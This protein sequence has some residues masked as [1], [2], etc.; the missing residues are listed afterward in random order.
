VPELGGFDIAELGKRSAS[1][2]PWLP[3]PKWSDLENRHRLSIDLVVVVNL[4]FE[5]GRDFVQAPLANGQVNVPKVFYA[6]CHDR[7]R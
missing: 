6:E 2:L 3:T 4:F 7:E 1:C 5:F